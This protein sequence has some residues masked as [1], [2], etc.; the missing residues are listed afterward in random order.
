M[1]QNTT[2]SN[3]LT[4]G[5]AK[6]RYDNIAKKLLSEKILLAWI[7]K[8]C[9]KEYKD[10]SV[11]DIA[12]KYING[13]PKLSAVS[14]NQDTESGTSRIPSGGTEDTTINEGTV[15]YDIHYHAYVPTIYGIVHLI[16]N[17]EPQ[18]DYYPGY[19][20]LTRGIYYGTRMISAQSGTLFQ[21]D[22][23]NEIRKVYSIW[24]CTNPPK[25]RENTITSYQIKEENIVGDVKEKEIA[26]D[27]M[28]VIMICLGD[29]DKTEHKI[30]RLL[31]IIFKDTSSLDE[32][33]KNLVEEFNIPMTKEIEREVESMCN[34]SEGIE[35]RGIER[36]IERGKIMLIKTKIEK[37]KSLETI[38]DEL[39]CGMEEISVLYEAVTRCG[40]KCSIDDVLEYLGREHK[41]G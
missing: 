40:S 22:E 2:F 24:I 7:M 20:L 19:I 1:Q 38:A 6:T 9:M 31:D 27:L 23:Y 5:D 8:H 25:K 34:L 13:I 33:K 39:E 18:N 30:L 16:I 36:G 14:V 3:T 10:I 11:E 37:S 41:E 12:S 29:S 28:N 32:K 4:L 17:I 21:S 15:T 35:R 26:Y